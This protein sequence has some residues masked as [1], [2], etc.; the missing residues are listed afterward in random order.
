MDIYLYMYTYTHTD[1]YVYIY[2]HRHVCIHTV[3]EADRKPLAYGFIC[4][5]NSTSMQPGAANAG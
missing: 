2:I 4:E 5:A 1:I 3:L